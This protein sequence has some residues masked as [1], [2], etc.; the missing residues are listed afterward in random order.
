[1]T[2]ALKKDATGWLIHGWTWTGP[3]APKVT[4]KK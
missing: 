3:T 2:F 4:G 1:M